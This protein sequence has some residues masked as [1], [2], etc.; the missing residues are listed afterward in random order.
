MHVHVHVYV[1]K[2]EYYHVFGLLQVLDMCAAPG[3]KTAQLI[4][5]IHANDG[6]SPSAASLPGIWYTC[7][8]ECT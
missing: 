2:P 5:M 3:S 8:W 7:M 6:G 1:Y 4:E